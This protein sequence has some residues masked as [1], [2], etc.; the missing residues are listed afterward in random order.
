MPAM[1]WRTVLGIPLNPDALRRL[2][3]KKLR[4]LIQHSY[5][6]V[7]YYRNLFNKVGLEPED[8]QTIDDLYKIPITRKTD[9]A[10]RPVDEVLASDYPVDHCFVTR[11]SGTTGHSVDRLL[12]TE[13]QVDTQFIIFTSVP[14]MGI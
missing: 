2:Q 11:T 10:D 1:M 6:H 4:A 12:G 13:S 7:P 3:N 8:I 14:R 9:L 5:A